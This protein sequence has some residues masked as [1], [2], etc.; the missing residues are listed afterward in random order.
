MPTRL[1]W[2]LVIPWGLFLLSL[3]LPVFLF[4]DNPPLLGIW[5]LLWGWG[6]LLTSNFAWL[7][8]P[9]FFIST[10]FAVRRRFTPA[11]RTAVISVL[12]GLLAFF[13]EA[14]WFDEASGTPITGFATG[15]YLWLASLAALSVVTALLFSLARRARTAPLP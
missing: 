1:L 15:F 3:F 6:G 14:W 4:E 11:F 9:L 10:F 5:V 12:V 7:A 2:F 8:T 13:S